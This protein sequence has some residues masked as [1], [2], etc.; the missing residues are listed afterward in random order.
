MGITVYGIFLI[1]GNAG[2]MSSTVGG[3]HCL[4]LARL[5]GCARLNK[6]KGS[7]GVLSGSGLRV[8]GALKKKTKP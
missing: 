1:M 4:C 6:N 3:S 8:F 7:I 2:F 5:S